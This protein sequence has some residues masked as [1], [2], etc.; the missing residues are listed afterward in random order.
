[1]FLD[2]KVRATTTLVTLSVLGAVFVG[3]GAFVARSA[4]TAVPLFA[5]LFFAAFL[6]AG[7]FFLAGWMRVVVD[8][9]AITCSVLLAKYSVPLADVVRYEIVELP[10]RHAPIARLPRPFARR[11]QA[12]PA[13][14]WAAWRRARAA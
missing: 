2:Q 9:A 5:G 3:I 11:R 13:R 1:M 6:V 14:R 7:N 8:E 10:A 12:A 4:G